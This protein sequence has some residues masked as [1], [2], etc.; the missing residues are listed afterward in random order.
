MGE[1]KAG[2]I[3]KYILSSDILERD[4]TLSIYLPEDFTE[5]FKSQVIICFDGLDFF[6]FGRIQREYE[7]LRKE[8]H[9]ERAIIVGFHYEDVEKRREE[10]HPQGSRSQ[11]TIQSVV[12]E[13][14][15]FID[16]TFPTY[17]VGNSRLL[18]GDSLSWKYCLSYFID[19]SFNI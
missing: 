7:R 4:I 13:L 1:F 3:N 19:L 18:I 2:K 11:K 12:K 8:E 14:L 15:P 16:Q 10:F 9:I 5:L 6:R 17:K